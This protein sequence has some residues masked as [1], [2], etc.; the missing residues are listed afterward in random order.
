MEDLLDLVRL[1][2]K[3][4]HEKVYRYDVG[5]LFSE[6]MKGSSILHKIL[7]GL[8]VG[9]RYLFELSKHLN[10]SGIRDSK[11]F[12]SCYDYGSAMNVE[13]LF[14]KINE[15]IPIERIAPRDM[16][17]LILWDVSTWQRIFGKMKK[18]RKRY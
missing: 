11:I 16:A 6:G 7:Y 15:R 9:H 8:G 17:K 12:R 13:E 1:L 3:K 10:Q 18:S 4:V 2:V 14:K 5:V